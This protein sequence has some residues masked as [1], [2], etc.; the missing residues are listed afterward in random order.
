MSQ[1]RS[2]KVKPDADKNQLPTNS[3]LNF[4]AL[5]EED[6]LASSSLTFLEWIEAAQQSKVCCFVVLN[7][8]TDIAFT[9]GGHGA[10][11]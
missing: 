9:R 3:D 11:H 8:L 6:E 7:S 1:Y 10:K 5:D 2:L 4:T